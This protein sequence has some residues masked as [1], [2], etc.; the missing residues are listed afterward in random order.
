MNTRGFTLIEL[1]V[2]VAIIGFLASIL[3]GSLTT[4]RLKAADS[5][6]RQEALQLRTLM[7]QERTNTGSYQNI[8]AG[9]G[10][11]TWR[12]VTTPTCSAANF[13][14]Q[15]A[16]QAAQVCTA[17]VQAAITGSSVS[18]GCG[19]SCV[20]FKTTSPDSTTKYSIQ[21]YLPYASS[22]AG[23]ARYFCIGSSGNQSISPGSSWSDDGCYTNP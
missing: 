19:T 13:G 12:G 10:A 9:P 15:F 2:V 11:P 3:L 16:S 17:L 5:A 4:A 6:V 22:I 14:G 8:K 7:E 1:L 20:Y 18:T 21:A 23:A